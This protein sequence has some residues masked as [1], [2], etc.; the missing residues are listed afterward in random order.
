[1]YLTNILS[2]RAAAVTETGRVFIAEDCTNTILVWNSISD[3]TTNQAPDFVLDSDNA[4]TNCT[5]LRV[6]PNAELAIVG[7]DLVFV[8]DRESCIFV[9]RDADSLTDTSTPDVEIPAIN[10]F[11]S[12]S[13]HTATDR[14]FGLESGGD[15]D[16]NI[17]VFENFSSISGLI[18]ASDA[19]VSDPNIS[20]ITVQGDNLYG[21]D[22]QNNTHNGVSVFDLTSLSNAQFPD[23][24][25]FGDNELF[26]QIDQPFSVALAGEKL[27]VGNKSSGVDGDVYNR[28]YVTGFSNPTALTEG[29]KPSVTLSQ[30]LT[31]G[32]RG[33]LTINGSLIVAN[34][35]DSVLNI[36]TNPAAVT[37]AS[38]PD[39]VLFAPN[40]P[41]DMAGT[42]RQAD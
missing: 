31:A 25:L 7:G 11:H 36:Y 6:G 35:S 22:T 41:A 12:A 29:Q 14:L 37:S 28:P 16:V 20:K 4:G 1:M 17:K 18:S 23:T 15:G 3:I 8:A 9:F 10:N 40:D 19:T 21:L 39:I 30:G 34:L 33:M 24:Y 5:G 27:F 13:V 38:S 26:S 42:V 32:A 2:P